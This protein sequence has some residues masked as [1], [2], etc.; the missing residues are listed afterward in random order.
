MEWR[1]VVKDLLS[2]SKSFEVGFEGSEVRVR[3]AGGRVKAGVRLGELRKY[4][5]RK[6]IK[7]EL[8][9][10]ALGL[11]ERLIEAKV[12]FKFTV[13]SGEFIIRFDL[14]HYIRVHGDG[15]SVIGFRDL[16]EHPVGLLIDLL[17]GHGPVR[18]LSPVR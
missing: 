11:V 6:G 1:D 16:S 15:A 14:D 9:R 8:R 7:A 3:E 4:A 18:L 17:R 13:G 2:Q 5:G 12:P 10:V